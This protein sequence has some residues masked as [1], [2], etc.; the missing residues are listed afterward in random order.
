MSSTRKTLLLILLPAGM[1]LLR[2][3]FEAEYVDFNMDKARQLLV[4]RSFAEGRGFS[5]RTADPADLA[6]DRDTPVYWWPPGYAFLVASLRPLAGEDELRAALLLDMAGVAVLVGG[7]I[8]LAGALR[9]PRRSWLP[10]AVFTAFTFTPYYYAGSTDLLS[11][12]F[13]VLAAALAV[14][15]VTRKEPPRRTAFLALGAL[16]FTP[17]FFRYAY[18]PMAA[19]IPLVL[20]LHGRRTRE[21]AYTTGGLLAA[22]TAVLLLAGQTLFNLACFGEPIRHR[23]GEGFHLENL[24][25]VD[26]FP[27]RALFFT[28]VI[29]KNAEALLG[30]AAASTLP[31]LWMLL[32]L[33]VLGLVVRCFLLHRNGT[34]PEGKGEPEKKGGIH[35]FHV[36]LFFTLAVNVGLLAW[37]SLRNPAERGWTDFWTYVQEPRYYLPTVLLLQAALFLG[38]A[39]GP[40]LERGF[41]ILLHGLLAAAVCFA[42]AWW[43]YRTWKHA[44][45]HAHTRFEF[46]EM[47]TAAVLEAA[48]RLRADGADRIV[49][50]DALGMHNPC[51]AALRGRLPVVLDY[52]ALLTPPLRYSAPVT[53]LLRMRLNPTLLE[54]EFLAHH[55]HRLVKRL[56]RTGL[57]RVEL[58]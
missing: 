47:E 5:L 26:P 19:V 25:H 3:R 2:S 51:L 38:I 24:L 31:L 41:R 54:Q 6:K 49:Y 20:W 40:R 46:R 18:Y 45:H 37:Y 34:L 9:P 55:P 23:P 7:L 4:A 14:R 50:A 22:G 57:W 10:F 56:Y 42:P 53:L 15:A 48:E 58:R 11:A 30:P 44:V 32:S 33:A 8:L 29:D 13:Y 39:E 17:A 52:P 12:A 35:A 36:L 43:G 21:R 27:A 1:L 28:D 16:A